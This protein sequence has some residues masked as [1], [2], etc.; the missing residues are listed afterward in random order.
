M[1]YMAHFFFVRG[2]ICKRCFTLRT[3]DYFR[4]LCNTVFLL[5]VNCCYEEKMRKDM[6]S[7]FSYFEKHIACGLRNEALLVRF[8]PY[9]NVGMLFKFYRL[10]VK[11]NI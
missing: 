6:A 9:N 7:I 11:E 10:H 3:I 2:C 1:F 8:G 5:R 4:H